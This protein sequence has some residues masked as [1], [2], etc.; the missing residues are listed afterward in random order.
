MILTKYISERSKPYDWQSHRET[1]N[2]KHP[3]GYDDWSSEGCEID[4][5]YN[6]SEDV[7]TCFCNHLTSFCMLLVS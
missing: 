4:E 5:N 1:S 2:S 7:V 6:D 3:D